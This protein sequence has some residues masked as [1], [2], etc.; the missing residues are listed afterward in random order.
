MI[1]VVGGM[2]LHGSLAENLK[3]AVGSAERLRGHPVHADTL[4][5]W[6]ELLA[7][8]RMRLRASS[9]ADATVEE[10]TGRLQAL[11]AE[12]EQA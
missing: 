9:K 11:L 7:H 4:R 2:E 8:A 3:A 12:R 1:G 10:L 5:F 6:E